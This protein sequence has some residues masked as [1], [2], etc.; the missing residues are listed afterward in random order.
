M[1]WAVS[2]VEK[3]HR[4][5]PKLAPRLPWAIPVPLA[6]GAPGEGYPWHWSVVPWLQG[7]TATQDRITNLREAATLLARLVAALQRV[8]PTGGPPPGAHNFGRGQPLRERDAETRDAIA[9]LTGMVDT[10]SITAA[11]NGA[12][13]SEWDRP[14]VWI[15][16]DLAPG[17]LL[18]EHGR[19]TAVIDWGGLGVGDPACDLMI[20]WTL[21]SGESRDVFRA[22]VAVDD[23]TWVRGR[24]W[25]LSWA[26]IFIPYYVDTNPE[27][28]R[29]ARHT[30]DEVL[31]D[32]RDP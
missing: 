3:E 22:A 11:W 9:S 2:E 6:N 27:G 10:D 12:L 15:H 17:N 26:L 23:A 30:I 25:A 16:G 21:F 7:E 28:V 24:G 5:L 32:L 8:D 1:D 4:C 19:L 20:A 18:V 13:H 31:A 29:T 14:P